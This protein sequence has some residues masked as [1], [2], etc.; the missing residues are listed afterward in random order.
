M[1]G[2]SIALGAALGAAIVSA[3]AAAAVAA[4]AIVT[5]I[6]VRYDD[7]DLASEAGA[8]ALLARLDAAA[9]KACGGRPAPVMPGD[10]VGIARGGEYRRCKAAALENSTRRLGSPLVRAAWLERPESSAARARESVAVRR[11]DA[12]AAGS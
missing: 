9:A 8:R 6:G 2:F 7:L 10:P 5:D 11:D 12:A 1:K 3:P 4:P